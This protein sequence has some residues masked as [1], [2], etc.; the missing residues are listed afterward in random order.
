MNMPEARPSSGNVI[1]CICQSVIYN[2]TSR[3]KL[4]FRK[5]VCV[6]F[7]RFLCE[8]WHQN[9]M[10][11]RAV[12]GV[13]LA[14]TNKPNWR[15]QTISCQSDQLLANENPPFV[16][17]C[18]CCVRLSKRMRHSR[19]DMADRFDQHSMRN[20]SL[21]FLRLQ[22][23]SEIRRRCCRNEISFARNQIGLN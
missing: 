9:D 1:H 4:I 6:N 5:C 12:R 11:R 14:N 7:M 16:C 3:R 20:S 15:G 19:I 22:K 13:S 2:P 10:H 8:T 21:L 17:V 23:K 18:A